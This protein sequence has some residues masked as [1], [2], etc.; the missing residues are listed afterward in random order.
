MGFRKLGFIR[1]FG[2]QSQ[3]SWLI[4]CN[5]GRISHS[6][7]NQGSHTRPFES[8]LHFDLTSR[9]AIC[10]NKGRILQDR[11]P[12][13]D[14]ET[15][16][17]HRGSRLGCRKQSHLRWF[18]TLWNWRNIEV[19]QCWGIQCLRKLGQTSHKFRQFTSYQSLFGIRKIYSCSFL[20]T[21]KIEMGLII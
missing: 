3:E 2:T 16:Q 13:V 14:W 4:R 17:I 1:L 12:L 11:S 21:R 7:L 18:L 20:S 5:T 15:Q 6:C 9:G 19:I 8:F 10:S